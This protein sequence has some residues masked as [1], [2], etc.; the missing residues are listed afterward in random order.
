M[1][2]HMP[3]VPGYSEAE[4][5]AA[6]VGAGRWSEVLAALGLRYHGRTIVVARKWAGRWGI[7]VDHLSDYRNRPPLGL[8]HGE[9][10]LR[11]AVARSLSWSATLRELGYCPTGGNWKTL[12]RR[13]A[14]LGIST[15]HF[16]PHAANRVA[17]RRRRIPLE[18][19]L[20]RGSTYSRTNLKA[21]LF[22]ANLKE[23]LCELCGQGETWHGRKMGLILDHVN[24]VRDDNRLA[25]LRIVCPNCAATLETHCGRKNRLPRELVPC[26]VCGGSFEVRYPGHRFC[27]V[28]CGA[29]GRNVTRG[30]PRVARRKVVRPPYAQ[31]IAEVDALG[32]AAVGRKHGVSDNAIRKWL[33]WYEREGRADDPAHA[34]A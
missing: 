24:G 26:A 4:L 16:D 11:D 31:L 32:F 14:E 7:P 27:S 1:F 12:K 20:V 5:R 34:A 10:E 6:V 33:A 29:R 19:I 2:A 25:N 18:E 28:A 13:C 30:R 3:W 17:G 22:E 21:R 15:D 9:R 23:R 8:R